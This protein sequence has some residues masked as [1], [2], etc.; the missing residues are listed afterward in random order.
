MEVGPSHPRSDYIRTDHAACNLKG[1]CVHA[2]THSK[3]Y[4]NLTETKNMV[5]SLTGILVGWPWKYLGNHK[6]LLLLPWVVHSIYSY[7]TKEAEE[8]DFLYLYVFPL[9]LWRWIHNQMW[10][11]FAR[12]RTAK[13][14]DLLVEKGLEFEQVVAE[15]D[16]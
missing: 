1:S 15:E 2:K 11:T 3:L 14:Y 9:L 8:R 4:R 7:I 12:H 5:S 6:Y 10:S 13:G 16:W